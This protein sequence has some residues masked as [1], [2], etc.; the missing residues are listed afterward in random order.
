MRVAISHGCCKSATG[1]AR[2]VSGQETVLVTV[3]GPSDG[4][5]KTDDNPVLNVDVRV[6]IAAAPRA[7]ENFVAGLLSAVLRRYVI[8]ETDPFKTLTVSVYSNTADMSVICNTALVACIDGGVPLHR[9]FIAATPDAGT[10]CDSDAGSSTGCGQASPLLGQPAAARP[11]ALPGGLIIFE[12][13]RPVLQHGAGEF[14][15]EAVERARRETEYI[16]ESIE[17][18]LG[19]MF[20]FD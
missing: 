20:K 7:S 2:T 19:D 11:C 16:R 3:H 6:R 17:Y 8:L 4:P 15:D 12:D 13:G 5:N 18:A 9:L 14:A 1:S 10:G